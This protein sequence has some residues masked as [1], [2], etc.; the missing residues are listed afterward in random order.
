[1]RLTKTQLKRLIRE[2]LTGISEVY[3]DEGDLEQTTTTFVP[4]EQER[5]EGEIRRL[6]DIIDEQN[7]NIA[8]LNDTIARLERPDPIAE[9]GVNK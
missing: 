5:L 7:Q 4:T 2:E 8:L 1:M 3:E 6:R 9:G